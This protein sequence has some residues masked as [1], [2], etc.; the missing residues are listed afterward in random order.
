MATTCKQQPECGQGELYPAG[1]TT[2]EKATC[3]ECNSGQYQ[4]LPAH[5]KEACKDQLSECGKGTK[6]SPE[7]KTADRTCIDC[8][9]GKTKYNDLEDHARLICKSQPQCYSG[10]KISA[11]INTASRTCATCEAN[12][13]Q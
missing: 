2:E 7:T 1:T 10:Q 13:Y 5:R 9:D 12:T 3:Q 11:P 8:G 6:I 4:D